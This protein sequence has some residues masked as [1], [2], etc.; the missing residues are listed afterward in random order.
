MWEEAARRLY[1]SITLDRDQVVLL[2]AGR[3]WKL[4]PDHASATKPENRAPVKLAQRTRLALSF[5][6][7][8]KILGYWTTAIV[9]MLWDA[10]AQGARPLF[11]NVEQL[12]LDIGPPC[13]SYPP[14]IQCELPSPPTFYIFDT[15]DVCLLGDESKDLLFKLPAKRY[16]SVTCHEVLL[17]SWLWRERSGLGTTWDEWRCFASDA[18][19]AIQ[20]AAS[21]LNRL[22]W[23][24]YEHGRVPKWDLPP[25]QVCLNYGE[26]LGSDIIEHFE[27]QYPDHGMRVIRDAPHIVQIEHFPPDGDGCEPCELCS[28]TWRSQELVEKRR[29]RAVGPSLAL[30][31]SLRW[32]SNEESEESTED[33]TVGTGTGSSGTGSSE[34]TES[35]SGS[36]EASAAGSSEES[37]EQSSHSSSQGLSP[38]SEEPPTSDGTLASALVS[39]DPSEAT[40]ENSTDRLRA[41]ISEMAILP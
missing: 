33:S 16:R 7:R 10:A 8:L 29:W 28:E 39:E 30:L 21:D 19:E 26:S 20:V 6:R 9:E 27:D 41:A 37:S 40:T 31:K 25:L 22:T 24:D 36:N 14:W 18:W 12:L 15:V 2:I 4:R 38:I 34:E 17:G 3:G 1:A 35:G 23:D 5:V 32:H 13:V 11:P